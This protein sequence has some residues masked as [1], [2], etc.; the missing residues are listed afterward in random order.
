VFPLLVDHMDGRRSVGEIAEL[1]QDRV[2]A[3]EIMCALELG[4][5]HQFILDGPQESSKLATFCF[6]LL[7]AIWPFQTSHRHKRCAARV[8]C[9]FQGVTDVPC[10]G[11]ENEREVPVPQAL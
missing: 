11:C 2:I 6:L 8:S 3:L 4:E 5:R 10:D 1:L 9:T 7:L